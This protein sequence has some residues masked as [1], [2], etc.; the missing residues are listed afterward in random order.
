MKEIFP[1]WP[2]QFSE[3]K[4]Y[5]SSFV[6]ENFKLGNVMPES[7][8]KEFYQFMAEI[9]KYISKD[10][11]VTVIPGLEEFLTSKSFTEVYQIVKSIVQDLGPSL[12]D[13]LNL[14]YGKLE[15]A[16][17]L[18]LEDYKTTTFGDVLDALDVP[19]DALNAVNSVVGFVANKVTVKQMFDAVG[20][21]K[22]NDFL[23]AAKK[24]VVNT[25]NDKFI[26]VPNAVDLIV[27]LLSLAPATYKRIVEIAVDKTIMPVLDEYVFA[28]VN[29]FDR[30]IPKRAEAIVELLEKLQAYPSKIPTPKD[31]LEYATKYA[32]RK[33]VAE[34]LEEIFCPDDNRECEK[35]PYPTAIKKIK[36]FTSKT[37][38]IQKVLV[39]E[40]GL[41]KQQVK[42]VSDVI[43]AFTN[44]EATFA[45]LLDALA[46]LSDD[47]FEIPPWDEEH[48]LKEYAGYLKK[49]IEFTRNID[50]NSNIKTLLVDIKLEHVYNG[51]K[52]F[53]ENLAKQ[54]DFY[55]VSGGVMSLPTLEVKSI[56]Y[57]YK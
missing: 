40:F 6:N 9:Q 5:A 13:A 57:I 54:V 23:A 29:I 44:P 35:D 28:V 11:K 10:T 24:F 43:N 25:E 39:D 3:Y 16:T 14:D 19:T 4:K 46:G 42:A 15:K 22:F 26:S 31:S 47:D 12:C 41:T 48:T 27:N 17:L 20:V 38:N 50:G 34:M 52:A 33:S 51:V 37:L 56:H 49:I 36:L 8:F 45:D 53:I 21:D 18:V 7:E 1:E 55:R 2:L 30:N 32:V